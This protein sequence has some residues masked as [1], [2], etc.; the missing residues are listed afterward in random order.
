VGAV[1]AATLLVGGVLVA[2][3]TS[4]LNEVIVEDM[5]GASKFYAQR[6][7]N[8]K[9]PIEVAGRYVVFVR[10][11]RPFN[12]DFWTKMYYPDPDSA[13]KARNSLEKVLAS[14]GITF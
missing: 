1:S 5:F 9:G 13:S 14:L 8:L 11:W 3:D 10:C 12:K 6:I 2:D 7:R 4:E